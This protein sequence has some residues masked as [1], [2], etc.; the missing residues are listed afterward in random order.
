MRE[1]IL[2]SLK[3]QNKLAID[4]VSGNL[5]I[6]DYNTN[7]I[8]VFDKAGHYLYHI[9]RPRAIGLCLSD[10][11]IFVTT[12]GAE[13][14]KIQISNKKTVKSVAT[15]EMVYGLDISNNIYGC[16][17]DNKS[18]IVYDKKL[19]FLKR[20]HLKSANITDTYS[21]SIRLYENSMY[22]MFDGSGYRI[23]VFSQDGQLIRGVIPSSDIGYSF[24]FSI[25]RIGNII[26]ADCSGHRII[27]FSNS[28]NLIHTISNDK[29]T[30]D[31]WLD[32]PMGICVDKQ[33]NI[34]VTH[35]NKKCNP[36]AF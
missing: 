20:I 28:G 24:F 26:A 34:V 33:N 8:Q 22:V 25:D 1:L 16:E 32:S 18:V 7:K 23:Q 30:E 4:T 2:V 5:F 14:V 17:S 12:G 35:K 31:H 29:L 27:I 21:Y 3:I 9:I 10:D 19:N 13:L 6:A 11:F 15:Q 36:I